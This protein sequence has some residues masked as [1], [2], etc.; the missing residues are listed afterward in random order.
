MNMK[1]SIVFSSITI[2]AAAALLFAAGPVVAT[3][4]AWACGWGGGWRPYSYGG[5]GS[6]SNSVFGGTYGGYPSYGG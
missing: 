2:A 5:W 6:Y 1:T 3:H 4:Q